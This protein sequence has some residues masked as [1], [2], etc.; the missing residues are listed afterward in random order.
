MSEKPRRLRKN[1]PNDDTESDDIFDDSEDDDDFETV[2]SDE[3]DDD[4]DSDEESEDDV[5]P[6]K[7]NRNK[8]IIQDESDDESIA[9]YISRHFPS[10]K[11][12]DTKDKAKNKPISKEMVRS[13]GKNYRV[14]QN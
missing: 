13:S 3:E 11:K 8:R 5:V 10:S 12:K 6:V 2:D 9:N 1:R 14:N 4:S 7:K